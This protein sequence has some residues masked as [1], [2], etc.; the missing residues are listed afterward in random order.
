MAE[1]PRLEGARAR[2]TREPTCPRPTMPTVLPASSVPTNFDF[3]HGPP[4]SKPLPR[5]RAAGARTARRTCARPPRRRCR[6]ASS[7]RA[8]RAPRRPSTSTLS[9]PDARPPDDGELRRRREKCRVHLRRA[10]HE[11]RVGVLERREQLLPGA[12]PARSTT[13]CPALRSSSSPADET[14][15]ATTTRLTRPPRPRTRRG[16]SGASRARRGPRRPCGRCG[17]SRAST[18]RSRR[19]S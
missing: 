8:R 7:G 9:T 14:F 6:S 13:S 11:E 5:D 3:S 19:R 16:P 1:Q 10:A 2:A 17:S 18:C 4:P 12:R 15:S